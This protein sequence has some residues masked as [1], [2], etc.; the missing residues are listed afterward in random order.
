MLSRLG[1]L[2]VHRR[3]LVLAL[4][5]LAIA[6][7]GV[8][9]SSVLDKLTTGGFADP[10]SQSEQARLALLRQFDEGAPN[11]VLLVS[12]EQGTVDSPDVAAAASTLTRKVSEEPGVDQVWSYWSPG[13]PSPLRSDDGRQGLVLVRVHGDDDAV[14]KAATSF[15]PRYT[16]DGP[17]ITSRVGGSG[18]IARQV[19]DQIR[20]DLARAEMLSMPAL[21][22]LLVLVFGTL[23]AAGLPL[24]IGLVS[25]VGTLLVLRVLASLTDVSIFAM[26]LT[27]ALGLGLAIDYSLFLVARYREERRRGLAHEDAVVRSVETAG[28]TVLFSAATVAA[29]LSALLLF[30]TVFLRSFAYAGIAV[31]ALS[32]TGALV[33]LPALLAVAGP[34]L[35]RWALNPMRNPGGLHQRPR[36]GFWH[37]LAVAVMRRPVLAGGA[38]LALLLVL[39]AP[40]LRATFALPDYRVLPEDTSSRQVQEAI[41][42]GFARGEADNLFVVAT[43]PPGTDLHRPDIDRYAGALSRVTGVAR[44]DAATGSYTEGRRV[45]AVP[46]DGARYVNASGTWLSVVPSVEPLSPQGEQLVEDVRAVP[47]PVPVQVGGASAQFVDTKS[48]LFDRLPL[49]L[50]VIAAVT[51]CVL[52]LFTGGLLVPIKGLVL[53]LLSLSA[54]F[55]ALV[56]VF[57]EGHLADRLQ[58]TPTGTLDLNMPILLFCVAFGL[59]MDYE[60]FMLSRIKER[61]DVTGDNQEAVAFGL[62]STGRLV[63]AAAALLS[64]V[65]L[66]F[67][68]SGISFIKLMGVGTALAVLLDATLV[69]GVLVPAFMRLAGR[70]NWWAPRPLRFLHDRLGLREGELSAPDETAPTAAPRQADAVEQRSVAD[71]NGQ[72]GRLTP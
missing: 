17:V 52:F 51:F 23:V 46:A 56:W 29:A 37:R 61:Y 13:S 62:E 14:A 41:D 60:V 58:F 66:A 64:V 67:A 6:L 36:P 34:H 49:A 63:T 21:I 57:Q 27:T 55:G 50:G 43:Q 70:A 47:S 48:A 54:T 38:V 16:T 32:A 2:T 45:G 35:D 8:L 71:A 28:R 65:F 25:V 7:A 72:G 59:S 20:K 33:V 24:A 22:V 4:G 18:E 12:A 44:V 3:R 42:R 53:N 15:S 10:S 31:V 40:F 26:N 19:Q 9:G 30:P 39:G 69:R 11:F 5:G 1:W 68:T